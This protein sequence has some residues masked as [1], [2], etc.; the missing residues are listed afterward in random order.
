MNLIDRYV[1]EVGK[2]LPRKNRL[3]I[4]TELRSTLEDMLEDRSQQTGRPADE[5]LADRIVAGIWRAKKSRCHVPDPSIPDRPAHVSHLH[6]G[7]ED[8]HVCG[9]AG[10]DDCYCRLIGQCKHDFTRILEVTG[11]IRRQPGQRADSS[12]RKCDAGLRHPGTDSA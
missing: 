1:T 5:A 4:E 2:H 8:C 12:L 6:I 7:A 3:D 10:L 11:R 9:H